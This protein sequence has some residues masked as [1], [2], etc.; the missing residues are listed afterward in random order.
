MS[1][2][3][4]KYISVN[5]ALST[6]KNAQSSDVGN[7][8]WYDGVLLFSLK[9]DSDQSKTKVGVKNKKTNMRIGGQNDCKYLD[10]K[11]KYKGN[12]IPLNLTTS[13]ID[14]YGNTMEDEFDICLGGIKPPAG[15]AEFEEL[16]AKNPDAKPRPGDKD[17]VMFLNE[18][19]NN[20]VESD[21]EGNPIIPEGTK[22][23]KL[24]DVLNIVSSAIAN[25]MK[26]SAANGKD[27]V[28]FVKA[29]RT[30]NKSISAAEILEKYNSEYPMIRSN[31]LLLLSNEDKN[32][33]QRGISKEDLKLILNEILILEPKL[34]PNLCVSGD[35]YSNGDLALNKYTKIKLMCSQA[36]GEILCPII[37]IKKSDENN[38][39]TRATIENSE[40]IEEPITISNIHRYI[41]RKSLVQGNYVTEISITKAGLSFTTKCNNMSVD[42]NNSNKKEVI[43]A[44]PLWVS[45]SSKKN[46]DDDESNDG[47]FDPIPNAPFGIELN[48]NDLNDAF[49]DNDSVSKNDNDNN[50]NDNNSNGND[51]DNNSNEEED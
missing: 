24:F 25:D 4:K 34:T 5:E 50:S 41:V 9:D 32:E 31:N 19:D 12:Y 35:Y 48:F 11:L 22:R 15:S 2:Y 45:K 42:I 20:I 10:V 1:A 16:R 18:Y 21:E 51:N 6:L 26:I 17:V 33:V 40:G 27:F 23:S 44:P 39:E 43:V 13:N 46:D 47:A 3:P 8:R 49:N 29:K 37:D 14:S 38:R 7:D 30:E 28:R 36:T